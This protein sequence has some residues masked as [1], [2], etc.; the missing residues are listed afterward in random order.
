MVIYCTTNLINGKKY[1]GYDVN[2]DSN[3]FGSGSDFS[4]AI[5]EC[6]KKNF[7][8]Q[9]LEY[10]DSFENL[11][12]A[13]IYWIDYFNA[14]KSDQFY[15][16]AKG[17]A[18]GSIYSKDNSLRDILCYD[19]NGLFLKKY[20]GIHN[21]ARDLRIGRSGIHYCYSGKVKRCKDYIFMPHKEGEEIKNKIEPY[22][23]SIV[24]KKR[25]SETID[26]IKKANTGQK[27][28]KEVCDKFREVRLA[29]NYRPT[30]ET[31]RKTSISHKG[32]K[33]SKEHIKKYSESQMLPVLQCD[34]KGNIISE[35]PSLR[36]ISE[37]LGVSRP[38]ICGALRGYT[39]TCKGFILKY[40]NKSRKI[41]Q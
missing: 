23:L 25:D 2:N 31:K 14:Q 3:Y 10:C 1:I 24:G 22:K 41:K 28:T 32:K 21:A 26:K 7:K 6:G 4:K 15:N 35:F 40:K 36:H 39:Q 38:T 13:E 34:L 16:K 20:K 9:I 30:E 27:R 8:K 19:L 17:G 11:K 29:L 18:G 37:H 33:K 12:E 5:K